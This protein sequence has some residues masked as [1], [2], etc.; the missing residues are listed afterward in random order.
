MA[1][2]IIVVALPA[3]RP[4]LSRLKVHSVRGLSALLAPRFGSNKKS[5]QGTTST[6][7]STPRGARFGHGQQS[8]S[9]HFGNASN[10]W[11]N[12]P[13]IEL[14]DVERQAGAVSDAESAPRRRAE[15]WEAIE[16]PRMI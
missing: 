15:P 3:L 8:S 16:L 2:Q 5:T 14:D 1:T 10:S 6:A 9:D 13:A 7:A 12:E 11:D 4:L